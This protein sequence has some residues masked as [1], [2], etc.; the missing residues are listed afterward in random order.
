MVCLL[1]YCFLLFIFLPFFFFICKHSTWNGIFVY[2]DKNALSSCSPKPFSSSILVLMN[3]IRKYFSFFFSY[4]GQISEQSSASISLTLCLRDWDGSAFSLGWLMCCWDRS[5]AM[6]AEISQ[7]LCGSHMLDIPIE[8]VKNSW[9]LG[10]DTMKPNAGIET[11]AR[12]VKC[13][14][15]TV[16]NDIFYFLWRE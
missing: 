8:T 12:A 9:S 13:V 10:T 15:E 3:W 14:T 16:I 6:C 7:G 1:S 5:P 11:I 4:G 2:A